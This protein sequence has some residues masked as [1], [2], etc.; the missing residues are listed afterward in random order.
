MF[1]EE[2]MFTEI[3]LKE[4]LRYEMQLEQRVF[5]HIQLDNE[6]EF[7]WELSALIKYCP[8]EENKREF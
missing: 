8:S 3:L 6:F 1:T 4:F 7:P 5:Q 2:K